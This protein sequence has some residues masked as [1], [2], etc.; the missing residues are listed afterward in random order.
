MKS[1]VTALKTKVELW[2]ERITNAYGESVAAIIEVGRQLVVAKQDCGYGGWGELT[3]R[4]TGKM[5]LPFSFQTAARFMAIANNAAIADVAHGRHLPASWRTLAVLASLD[6]DDIEAAIAD[7]TIHPEMERKDA[8]ALKAGIEAQR[9]P[10]LALSPSA[11]IVPITAPQMSPEERTAWEEGMKEGGQMIADFAE[12]LADREQVKAEL[13]QQP[14]HQAAAAT[15]RDILA[16]LEAAD[17][18][19]DGPDLAY[20]DIAFWDAAM[21]HATRIVTHL[22]KLTCK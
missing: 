8:E 17:R 19:L 18:L 11:E 21:R 10:K 13:A 22:E 5:L 12:R 15:Y 7:G 20:L 9:K 1:N 14:D 4:T 2:A 6:A 16:H 3:G